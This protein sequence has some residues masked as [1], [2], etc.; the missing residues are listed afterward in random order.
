MTA[1]RE[2]IRQLPAVGVEPGDAD[3]EVRARVG[4]DRLYG[5]DSSNATQ[6][7]EATSVRSPLHQ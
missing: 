2:I 1:T 4:G 7:V 3:R 6:L 5:K